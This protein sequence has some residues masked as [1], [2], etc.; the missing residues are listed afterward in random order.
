MPNVLRAR[1]RHNPNAAQS[2]CGKVILP[3]TVLR[4][5][6][7]VLKANKPAVLAELEKRTKA[8]L[9]PEP[10]LLKK[11][12]Q[13]FYNSSPLDLKKLMGDQDHIKKNLFA[14]YAGV[15][16]RAGEGESVTVTDKLRHF[17]PPSTA[18]SRFLDTVESS[19]S[20]RRGQ[21]PLTT[22][23]ASLGTLDS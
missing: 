9:N 22:V 19:A 2:E 14:L 4:R 21:N 11:S 12:G 5:P 1:M 15:T 13:L 20:L 18:F 6:D 3:F 16:R 10:F 7:C 8:G 17:Q 23:S